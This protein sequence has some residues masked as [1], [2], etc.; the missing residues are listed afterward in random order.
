[1][2][3]Y[4][5]LV[6]FIRSFGLH[7]AVCGNMDKFFLH[8]NISVRFTREKGDGF[9]AGTEQVR[10]YS[11]VETPKLLFAFGNFLGKNNI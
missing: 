11:I 1:M 4:W 6:Y 3:I 9:V 5:K 7:T 8:R 10:L 2:Q